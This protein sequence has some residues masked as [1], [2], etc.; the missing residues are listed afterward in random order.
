MRVVFLFNKC[1]GVDDRV[2][3]FWVT[4]KAGGWGHLRSNPF[5][6]IFPFNL[7]SLFHEGADFVAMS[8]RHN[9]GRGLFPGLCIVQ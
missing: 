8:Y 2:V 3:D 7:E 4:G 1:G 5:K 6:A 9:A